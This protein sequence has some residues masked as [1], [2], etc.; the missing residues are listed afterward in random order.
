MTNLNEIVTTLSIEDQ[1][2]FILFLEKKNKR[3]DTK[4][5]QLFKL[6]MKNELSSKEVCLKL[7]KTYK[8]D[9]YH[10]LRKRL[11]QSIID[12][13]ANSSLEE[14]KVIDMQII[15][16][17]LASRTFLLHK[18]YKV[19]YN[20]LDRAEVLAE[21]NNLFPLLN[22]IYHTKIQYA[23]SNPSV[24]LDELIE[25]FQINQKYYVQED[26]LNI[27]YAK[28]RESIN[29]VTVKGE[30]INF[31]NLV[32]ETLEIYGIDVTESMSFM[33]LYQL[34]K[35]VTI[36]A[37]ASND[38]LKIE[39]FLKNTYAILLTHKNKEKQLY[40]HIQVLYLLAYTLFRNKKFNESLEYLDMQ[41]D[42]MFQKKGKFYNEFKLKYKLLLALNLNFLN[43]QEEA[44]NILQPYLIS[45]HSDLESL[46][47]IHLSMVMMYFQKDDF[48]KAREIFSKFYH[49]DRWY[50]EKAGK[51]WVIKKNLIEILLHIELKNIDLVESRI[52]SFRRNYSK[53][54]KDIK[55]QRVL[56]YLNL[57]YD[58]FN[59][60][61]KIT[62]L[63]FKN[64]VELS[65]EWVSG[66]QEDIFVMSFYAWL[67]SKMER[68]PLLKTT[69]ELV[70]TAQIA[71]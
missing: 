53:F 36:S 34:M 27:A 67:K 25:K 17:I 59:A 30:F 31:Q 45:K 23:Y 63:A 44:I 54:L 21:D 16:Y 46:L 28:I 26:R 5:I 62:S 60:P 37:F 7:Y 51:E 19:A 41:N 70:K 3:L 68:K 4:N 40:Y 42:L 9:A 65:F 6:L 29:E 58:Y 66:K 24:K 39:P 20:I 57:V 1:Q 49:T 69:L 52:L 14:E 38:Y 47:D 13:T 55:Q 11:Y 33:S 50:I 56:T 32:N 48:Q 64:K 61:E 10:A 22:E 12:F 18:Q 15:K 35:I 2:H 43:S 8:K 71:N